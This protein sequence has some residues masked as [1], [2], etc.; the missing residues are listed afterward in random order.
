MGIA[1]I[2]GLFF[3]ALWL[4]I[5]IYQRVN[6]KRLKGKARKEIEQGNWRKAAEH[7]IAAILNRLDSGSALRQLVP[8]LQSIYEAQGLAIDPERIYRCP[9]ILKEINKSKQKGKVRGELM[10]KVY[11]ETEIYLKAPMT[12][13][14]RSPEVEAFYDAT[15]EAWSAGKLSV[16]SED[17]SGK[18]VAGGIASFKRNLHEELGKMMEPITKSHRLGAEEFLISGIAPSFLLTSEALYLFTKD[19]LGGPLEKIPLSEITDYSTKGWLKG[20]S[21]TITMKSGSVKEFGPLGGAP[22]DEYVRA[23]LTD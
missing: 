9:G 12:E 18:H 3:L 19:D 4:G 20:I 10:G 15:F 22:K 14:N 1:L 5:T 21:M 11:T 2:V 7:Q 17:Y 8:E 23:F 6:A 13:E 16:L